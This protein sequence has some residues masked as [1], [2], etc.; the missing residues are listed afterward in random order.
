MADYCTDTLTR[1]LLTKFNGPVCSSRWLQSHT[2][3]RSANCF[4]QYPYI[5]ALNLQRYKTHGDFFIWHTIIILFHGKYSVFC[6][7]SSLDDEIYNTVQNATNRM[8]K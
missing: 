3:A 1:K 4:T 2:N 5:L 6:R 8:V 7:F